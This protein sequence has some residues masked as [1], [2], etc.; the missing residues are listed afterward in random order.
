[1]RKDDTQFKVEDYEEFYSH[2]LF[3]P[4][5]DEVAFSAHRVFPRIQWALD[6]AKDIE[7]KRVLDLG[8]LEGYTALTLLTHCPSVEYVEGVDLSQEG[9]DGNELLVNCF[10]NHAEHQWSGSGVGVPAELRG[11]FIAIFRTLV[12]LC[13]VDGVLLVT[14]KACHTIHLKE[15]T[16]VTL[17]GNYWADTCLIVDFL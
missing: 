8:C 7:A 1:M 12:K 15:A 9:I 3:R 11:V 13:A 5:K 16:V 6:V 14:I 17:V 10:F 4:V 2:H